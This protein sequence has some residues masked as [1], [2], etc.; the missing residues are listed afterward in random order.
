M[1]IDLI[2]SFFFESLSYF[3]PE[4][5]KYKIEGTCLQCG[6]C[7]RE[8]R[9][10]GLKNEKEL[11]LMQIFLP[12]YRRFFI[13]GKDE[14]NNLVLSCKYLTGSGKCSVYK[15]RPFLC[16]NYPSKINFNAQMIE[17]CGYKVVKKE[18]KDYL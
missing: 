2:K 1:S 7:C 4:K 5:I 14:Y 16:K 18:F 8:I 17:N 13:T 10:Y 11:K 12:H 9:S 15:K 6:K 3:V